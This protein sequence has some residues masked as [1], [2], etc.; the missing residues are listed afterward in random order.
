MTTVEALRGLYVSLGGEAED[1]EDLV[2]IPDVINA[3]GRL[4][5]KESSEETDSESSEE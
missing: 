4:V 2:V 1:V 5:E 3:I